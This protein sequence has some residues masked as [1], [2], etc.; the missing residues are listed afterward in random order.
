MKLYKRVPNPDGCPGYREIEIHVGDP[1]CY[2]MYKL[3]LATK[4]DI[5]D[6]YWQQMEYRSS[7]KENVNYTMRAQAQHLFNDGGNIEVFE[8]E[9]EK[10]AGLPKR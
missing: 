2:T 8:R 10:I 7:M 9:M 6:E 1:F 4:E 3:G 5:S